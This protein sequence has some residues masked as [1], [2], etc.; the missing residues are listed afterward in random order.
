[1]AV[2]LDISAVAKSTVNWSK[3]L[4]LLDSATE[5]EHSDNMIL[6]MTRWEV[7]N[8][9]EDPVSGRPFVRNGFPGRIL[10]L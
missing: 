8:A 2:Y 7:K 4:P 6:F 1:M 3:K 5:I 10:L 9:G